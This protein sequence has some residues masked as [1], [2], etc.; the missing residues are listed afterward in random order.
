M[1]TDDEQ[2][3]IP[4]SGRTKSVADKFWD[5]FWAG[6]VGGGI[7]DKD[8]KAPGNVAHNTFRG[9]LWSP[10]CDWMTRAYAEGYKRGRADRYERKHLK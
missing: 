10:F 9:H 2:V 6:Y 5:W 3:R 7:N 1:M 8:T 4:R